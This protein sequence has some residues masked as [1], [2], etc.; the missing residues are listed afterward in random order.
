LAAGLVEKAERI[1]RY[2]FL[3]RHALTISFVTVLMY[4]Q[5]VSAMQVGLRLDNWK[6]NAAIGFAA[7]LIKV[8]YVSVLNRFVPAVRQNPAMHYMRKGSLLFWFLCILAGAFAEEFWIAICLVTFRETAYS[9]G[10]SVGLTA[11]VFGAMHFHY[12]FWGAVAQAMLGIIF[13]LLFL[14]TRSL[15]ATCLFHFIGNLGVLYWTRLRVTAP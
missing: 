4:W 6:N 9:V 3:L 7:G 11:I 14:W 15:I 12:R 5:S 1:D 8:V 10:A 13:C 2:T